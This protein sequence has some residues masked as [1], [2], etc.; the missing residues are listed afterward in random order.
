MVSASELENIRKAASACTYCGACQAVCP[1]FDKVG[2]E[3]ACSRGRL[4]QLCLMAEGV[5][6]PNASLAESITRCAL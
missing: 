2:A 3:A 5:I 4:L 1:V 6:D